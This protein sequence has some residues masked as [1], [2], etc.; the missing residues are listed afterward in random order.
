[1]RILIAPDS[2]KGSLSSKEVAD[3]LERGI[4]KVVKD[5]DIIKIPMAD[6]GEGTV[7]TLISAVGG[8]IVK[9]RVIGPLG[10]EVNA[11]FGILKDGKTAII[12]MAKASGL[13]LV[14]PEKRNP[15]ITTTYGTGQLIKKALDL[16]C[17]RIV[18]GIGGSA[19]NDGGVGM[20]QA[21]GVKFLDEKGQDIGFG[22]GELSRIA[23]ID[24]TGIDE[25]IKTAKI[26]VAC[27][28]ANP[29]CGPDGAAY[30]YGPQKGADEN[31]VK[32]LDDNLAHLA[33]VVERDLGRDIR[34]IPGAGAAGGLG[35]GL[36][37]FL[38][39]ELKK[40][41]DIVLN[42]TDFEKYVKKA[43]LVVTGEGQIDKQILNGKTVY[44]VC[45]VAKKYGVPVIA[46]VGSIR[47][48][49]YEL[50]D[51]GIDGI[52]SIIDKPMSLEEAFQ[53]ADLLV[54]RAGE[55][56]FRILLIDV[57]NKQKNYKINE[58]F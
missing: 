14:P 21:L 53:K 11:T 34:N 3:A 24:N 9:A 46:V 39:A 37:A 2:Y 28:V 17:G 51:Y 41:I 16:G 54:E 13:P 58:F 8:E 26:E 12:E 1:M 48:D 47:D 19:T 52:E 36:V 7:E 40:G 27:D 38:N 22:G 45:K 42:V 23:K 56:L 6:G 18:M 55:R 35:A 15:M 43:D 44:G 4:K 32:I 49:A 10:E 31:M 50:Y 5:V 29:L 57:Q 20:A 25:R 30:V 33:D